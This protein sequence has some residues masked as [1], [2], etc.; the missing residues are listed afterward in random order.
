MIYQ[1]ICQFRKLFVLIVVISVLNTVS[2]LAFAGSL[3][4]MSLVHELLNLVQSSPKIHQNSLPQPYRYLLTQPILTK[5]IEQ[6]YQR[7]TIIQKMYVIKKPND[8]YFRTIIMLIDTDKMRD[9]PRLA[10]KKKESSVVELA[11][12]TINLGALPELMKKEVLDSNIPFG[13]LISKY[14]IK[15]GIQNRSYFSTLCDIKLTA[16][17]PCNLK[18]KVYGRTNTLVKRENNLWIADV[19]EVLP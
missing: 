19:T 8:I 18:T 10:Q 2:V 11:F 5:G 14:N 17:I 13:T 1:M 15:V 12:I 3:N 4:S 6:Y 9:N 16:L 7:K